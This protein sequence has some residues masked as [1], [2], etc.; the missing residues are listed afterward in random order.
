M[1]AKTSYGILKGIEEVG[2]TSFS[3]EEIEQEKRFHVSQRFLTLIRGARKEDF[4]NELLRLFVVYRKQVPENLFSLLIESDKI[5][6][7]EK[8][9]AF[10]TGFINPKI[11]DKEEVENE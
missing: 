9:L 2:K 6:F 4:Y 7:Q 11:Q 3:L 10:L 5:T 1:S 8:A